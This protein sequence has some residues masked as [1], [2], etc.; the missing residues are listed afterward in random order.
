M[1][2]ECGKEMEMCY[3]FLAEQKKTGT[4]VPVYYLSGLRPLADAARHVPTIFVYVKPNKSPT[5][6]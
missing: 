1:N 4:H 3:P 6:S 2:G 5:R